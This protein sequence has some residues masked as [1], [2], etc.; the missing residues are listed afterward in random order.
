MLV[1]FA[2]QNG[3]E[4]SSRKTT[5]GRGQGGK[6]TIHTIPK[7]K[8]TTLS[9][10]NQ[11]SARRVVKSRVPSIIKSLITSQDITSKYM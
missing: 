9:R 10:Q 8:I 2:L 4:I 6:T 7:A 11:D 1:A 5:T 3:R